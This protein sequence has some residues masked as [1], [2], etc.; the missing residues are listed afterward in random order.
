MTE[1]KQR[2]LAIDGVDLRV[3]QQIDSID[4]FFTHSTQDIKNEFANIYAKAAWIDAN[5]NGSCVVG[6]FFIFHFFKEEDAM[7]F[8]LRWEE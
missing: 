7:A 4:T 5:L 1:D 6:P 2:L 8:K 3:Q